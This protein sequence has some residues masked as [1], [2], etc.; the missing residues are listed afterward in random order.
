M[1]KRGRVHTVVIGALDGAA[2]PLGQAVLDDP[3]RHVG[4]VYPDPLTV[5][6]LCRVDSGAAAAER[7]QDNVTPGCCCS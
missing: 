5:E 3:D 7:I 1:F 2:E 6:G 4:D